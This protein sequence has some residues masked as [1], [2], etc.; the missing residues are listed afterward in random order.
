MC[1][2]IYFSIHLQDKCDARCV[3][4]PF[5]VDGFP[6]MHIGRKSWFSQHKNSIAVL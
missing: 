5:A 6:D 1:E 3:D 2:I 4:A